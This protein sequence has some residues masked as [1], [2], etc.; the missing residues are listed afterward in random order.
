MS[1]T[2]H[3]RQFEYDGAYNSG[4][5]DDWSGFVQ[6]SWGH[7]LFEGETFS[8]TTEMPFALKFDDAPPMG[9]DDIV[10]FGSWLRHVAAEAK[11]SGHLR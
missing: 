1:D 5:E 10:R 8:K 9:A 4:G 7:I 11:R 3:R 6:A 2:F